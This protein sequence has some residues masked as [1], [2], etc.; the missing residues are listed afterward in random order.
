MLSFTTVVGIDESHLSQFK[1]VWPTWR[2]YRPEICSQPLLLICDGS[3]SHKEWKNRLSFLD[4]PNYSIKLWELPGV[5]Q[6]E[7][8]LSGLVFGVAHHVRTPWYLKLDTDAVATAAGDWIQGNWFEVNG[9]GRLPVFVASP[10]GY[11]KPPDA[12]ERLDKWG[13]TVPELAR[14]RELQL[15]PEPNSKLVRHSRVTSWCF[16]GRTDWTARVAAYCHD[17]LPVASHDTFLWYCA[18]RQGEFYRRVK[19]KRYGWSHVQRTRKIARICNEVLHSQPP[20]ADDRFSK[21]VAAK[22]AC[23]SHAMNLAPTGASRSRGVIYLLTGPGH[24]ARLIVSIW[25]LRRFYGGPITLF[26]TQPDSHR[27]GELCASDSR[28][29]VDHRRF[30]QVKSKKN[31]SLL[32]KIAILPESPYDDAVFLD[33]DTLVAGSIDE[34]FEFPRNV[35]F[36][37]VQF[38]GWH[39]AGK[40]MRKRIERWRDIDQNTFD[41]RW[42]NELVDQ[43]L[44]SRPAINVGVF[45][46]KRDD[47]LLS[48]WHKLAQ[49]GKQTFICDEIACQ[50]LLPNHPHR[51]LDSRFNFSPIHAG[52]PSDVRIWHFHGDKHLSNAK[53]RILWWPEYL[54]CLSENVAQLAEWSPGEDKHL[55]SHLQRIKQQD[56]CDRPP[57]VT[58]SSKNPSADL[59]QPRFRRRWFD[60][61][62]R[63]TFEQM[64]LP[65]W[66][67][68][69]NLL[70]LEIGVF[71]AASLRWMFEYVLTH[72]TSKAIGVDP[73]IATRKLVR[74][75]GEEGARSFMESCHENARFNLAPFA[76]RVQL[77]RNFSQVVIPIDSESSV[78][79]ND[80]LQSPY[81]SMLNRRKIER[82]Q[83]S[84]I[85]VALIDG[86]HQSD[87]VLRDAT[88]VLRHLKSGGWIMFDDYN[89]KVEKKG[90]VRDGYHRFLHNCRGQVQ[91]IWQHGHMIAVKKL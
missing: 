51:I 86:D 74:K 87:A 67:G 52:D 69:E 82:L 71:E 63:A 2:K 43:S 57:E 16:F 28:L 27:I 4:H 46:F 11:T 64:V 70:Y 81:V 35:Q 22:T 61:R 36:N 60:R 37:A 78:D 91:E 30:E 79:A 10:W 55:A 41:K 21:I 1:L 54:R 50:L 66:A 32:T 90:H 68:K 76:E 58:A 80:E 9:E 48:L 20:A 24:G 26:T 62:N 23:Q 72:L 45:G 15:H 39:T 34:L 33:A 40:T 88:A 44:V 29:R 42:I 7:K 14:H 17:R 83:D 73:W 6:R 49:A 12:I 47:S 13:N 31:S 84:S 18:E 3:H 85:D 53:C 56:E 77:I 89:N 75:Y 8:M 59:P 38:S 25:S 19:M 5:S 65:A